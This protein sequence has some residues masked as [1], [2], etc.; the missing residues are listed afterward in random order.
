[1]TLQAIDGGPDYYCSNGFTDACQAGWDSP[2]FFPIADDYAFY[3]GNHPATF[4][5]LGLNTSV[6]VTDDTDLATVRNAG[7]FAFPSPG[8]GTDTG[9][10]TTGWHIE[11][12]ST[13]ADITSQANTAGSAGR[14]FQ[15]SFTWNQ[16]AYGGL[17]GTPCG[18]TMQATMSCTIG[19]PAGRHL[20]IPTADIYWFACSTTSFCQQYTGPNLLDTTGNAMADQLARGSSYGDMVDQMR[21][22]VTAHP[23]P[24][25]PYIETGDGLVGSGSRNITPPEFNWAVWS[26]IVHGARMLLY[27]GTTSDEGSTSTFGFSKT[28]LPGQSVSM[29]AQAKATDGL[30]AS[31]APVINSPTAVGYVTAPDQTYSLGGPD[32]RPLATGVD[33]MA[34]DDNG[35]FYVFASPRGSESRGSFSETFTTADGYTGPV[36]V[37]GENRTVQATGGQFTDTFATGSTV[38]IYEIG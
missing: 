23:A 38:H 9:G 17:S 13:W 2:S 8:E 11:E 12:P 5:D 25:A 24:A 18:H 37:V 28:V 22:W 10:E 14:I 15:P 34:K 3:P 16:F 21:S 1:V 36:T 29:Y 4:K 30:V 32:A 7:L 6:R 33:L 31:L 20:D 35:T 26:T 27:F 19:M